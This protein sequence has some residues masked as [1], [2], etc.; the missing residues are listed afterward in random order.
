MIGPKTTAEDLL[1]AALASSDAGEWCL[2]D[3]P[4][5]VATFI[6]DARL[7]LARGSYGEGFRDGLLEAAE[8][9]VEERRK[10]DDMANQYQGLG[11]NREREEAEECSGA[12]HDCMSAILNLADQLDPTDG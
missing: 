4:E 5:P 6:A 8:T 2:G 12:C 1:I 11:K 3:A 10:W 7:L 9:C